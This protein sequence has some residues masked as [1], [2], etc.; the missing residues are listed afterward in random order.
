MSDQ[1]IPPAARSRLWQQVNEA[2]AAGLFRLQVCTRCDKVQYPPQE[3]CSL[4]LADELTWQQVSPMGKVLAWTTSRASTNQFFRDKFP[5]K[6]GLV[7]LDCGPVMVAYLSAS[8]L[9]TGSRV[10]VAGKPDMSG[11]VVFLAAPPDTDPTAEF[12]NILVEEVKHG[13]K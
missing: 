12:R 4:C 6:I 11:Q 7:K 5:L 8:C 2:A 1:S 9:Q 3:F 13:W 10:Q